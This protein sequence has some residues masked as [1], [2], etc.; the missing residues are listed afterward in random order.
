MKSKSEVLAA[1][2]ENNISFATVSGILTTKPALITRIDRD[3]PEISVITTKSYQVNPNQGNREPVIV[4]PAEGNFGNAVGLRNPGMVRGYEDLKSIR[5]KNSLR[6]LLNVS[7]SGNSVEEFI[8]LVKNFENIA[9]I[10]ELNLSCPHASGGYGM[11]IGTDPEIVYTYLKR[12]REITDKL[13]FPKLTPNV[14]AISE[15]ALAAVEGGADGISAINTV[16]P[17]LYI[18][19]FSGKPI[20]E[21]SSG[22]KGGMSGRWVKDTALE[23]VSEIRTAVGNELPIIGIGG[24]ETGEDVGNMINA[25]ADVVG[26]GSVFA[27][28]PPD[29]WKPFFTT[30]KSDAEKKLNNASVYRNKNRKMEYVPHKIMKITDLPGDVRVLELDGKIDFD[31][32]QFAFLWLPGIG[33]KPFSIMKGDSLTF[34]IRRK[35]RFTTAVMKLNENDTIFVRG[36]YGKDSP[37]TSKDIVYIAAGGTGLA[38]ALSLAEKLFHQGK[39]VHT[40]YGMSVPGQVILEDNFLKFGSFTSAADEDVPGRIL[41]VLKEKLHSVSEASIKK[42]TLYTIG[43]LPFMRKSSEIFISFNGLE[44]QKD[45]FLSIETP[46][47]CGIGLCGEC[48]C[49]GHLTCREGTFFPLSYLNNNKINLSELLHED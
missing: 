39:K 21:N 11:A 2:K 35:G 45:I 46:T 6:S 15:I 10:I 19:P 27:S 23:K 44:S 40:F 30:L 41:D 5:L 4:E 8:T 22:N 42:S 47:R 7:V 29:N 31:S 28:V 24:I 1:L 18:E 3:I 17:K 9:D 33:E 25:G 48:E 49:G 32:S 34:V 20:F 26:I 36:V 16:G 38:V 12:I 43:A 13:I 14:P 37:D